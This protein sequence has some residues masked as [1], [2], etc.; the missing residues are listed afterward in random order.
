MKEEGAAGA[1]RKK[2]PDATLA[3]ICKEYNFMR[4]T[5]H[6]MNKAIAK[7][8]GQRLVNRR[9]KFTTEDPVKIGEQVK[10]FII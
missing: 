7:Q 3:E 8:I 9:F 10:R 5:H 2:N 4:T 6:K 1:T